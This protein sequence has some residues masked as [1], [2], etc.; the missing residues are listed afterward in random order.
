MIIYKTRAILFFDLTD[1]DFRSITHVV[2]IERSTQLIRNQS[3]IWLLGILLNFKKNC[4]NK[5]WIVDKLC[6]GLK[7]ELPSYARPIFI[8]F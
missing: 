8:R 7:K 5:L 3:K 6:E 2:I 4:E 1:F